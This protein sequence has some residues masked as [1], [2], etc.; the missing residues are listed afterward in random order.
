MNRDTEIILMYRIQHILI[1]EQPFF[2]W[3]LEYIDKRYHKDK[4]NIQNWLKII[5]FAEKRGLGMD[6]HGTRKWKGQ[7]TRN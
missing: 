3:D 5:T 1:I 7:A 6:H 2:E 4:T